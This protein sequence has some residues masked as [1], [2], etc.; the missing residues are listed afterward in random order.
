MVAPLWTPAPEQIEAT[1][2]DRFRR[3]IEAARGVSLADT[4]EL[5]RW[6]IE[7][8]DEFWSEV[9]DAVGM[10]G[11]KG[12]T[13]FLPGSD[14]A[15]ARFFP[16][17]SLNVAENLLD[18]KDQPHDAAAIEFKREDGL[19]RTLTWADLRSEVAAVAAALR[20]M[21]I[22]PGDRVVAWMPHVPETVILMLAAASIGA[23]FS[24]TSADFGTAGVVDRFGQIE[25]KLLLAV[26][27]YRYGASDFDRL[28]ALAEIRA[29]LPT[30]ERVVVL[31]YL[32]D[33]PDLSSIA[34]AVTYEAFVAPHRGAKLEFAQL[35]FD[36]PWYILYSSG[37]TGKPKCMVHRAGGVLIKH[38]Q[39]HAHHID[40]RPGDRLFYFTT[41]GWMMWNWLVSGLGLGAAIVL[42]DGN[43]F[44]PGP[45]ALFDY[46]DE[47]GAKLMGVSAKYIDAVLKSGLRPV[48]SHDL[49]ALRIITSTGSPLSPDGFEFVYGGI[50]PDVHLASI[51]GG[52]DLCGCFVGGDPTRPVFAGEI[53]GAALGMR[54]EVFDDTGRGVHGQQGELVCSAPFPSMPLT[55][56]G[57]DG[58]RR[59]REAYFDR[60]PDVWTHG[61][62]AM[63]T[64]RG[65]MVILG[66]S[67]ATL[68]SGGVRIGTAEIYRVVEQFPEVVEAVAVAQRWDNDTRVVMFVRLVEGQELRPELEAEMRRRLRVEESPRHVPAIITTV[69]DIPR[70]RSGKIS[71]LAVTAVVNGDEVK[72][73]EALANPEALDLFRDRPELAR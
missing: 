26:D 5:H 21:G 25:P 33:D 16:E 67:D 10:I 22:E 39:E 49:S 30:L 55:F 29:E 7:H 46:M 56:W 32:G 3:H 4:A 43:P 2:I 54:M 14:M 72:N 52:T 57:E 15:S 36:H 37:T 1:N 48:E 58:D 70:T 59:Y 44:E 51:S 65:G 31:G 9:W 45:E 19:R 18:G 23:V 66:R 62:Y 13:A 28:E 68:N 12:S 40:V 60:F 61:D 24:S 47:V 17:A 63:W 50:K 34:G 71:E 53:Q 38:L 6:S 64:E 42:Y 35:P 8:L 11:E 73:T 69:A 20:A 27:G 41:C